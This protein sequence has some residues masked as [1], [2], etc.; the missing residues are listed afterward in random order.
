MGQMLVIQYA[1]TIIY[2]P[3]KQGMVRIN[4]EYYS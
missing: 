3:I 2:N 1:A 4:T